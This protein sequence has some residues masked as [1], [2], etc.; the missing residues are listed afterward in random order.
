MSN[1]RQ[2]GARRAAQAASEMARRH[3]QVHSRPLEYGVITGVQPLTVELIE[4]VEG[5]TGGPTPMVI[6]ETGLTLSAAVR[7]YD[8]DHLLAKGDTLALIQLSSEDFVALDVVTS[9]E[10][11]R[12]VDT[13]TID[14]GNLIIPV[15]GH[16]D[17]EGGG[18]D[19]GEI[20][21]PILFKLR[22]RDE[23]G[24][25]VGWIPVFPPGFLPGAEP[26]KPGPP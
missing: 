20:T 9:A 18:G 26:T 14:A 6:D 17:P 11:T 7:R 25:V 5:S 2:S 21:L 19:A 8:L 16:T 12:G 3:I 13:W 22:I 15:E 24:V 1:Q 23:L 10:V 4:G